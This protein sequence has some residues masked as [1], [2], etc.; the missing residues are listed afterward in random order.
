VITDF[1]SIQP[2]D[3]R[4]AGS[5]KWSLFPDTIG[6]F[7]AEMDFGTAPEVTAALHDI[8]DQGL[9]GYLPPWLAESVSVACAEWQAKQYGWAVPSSRVHPIADVIKGLEI[10][11]EHYSRP[12]SPVIM[13][14]PAYMPFLTV[15][16]GLGRSIIQVPLAEEDGRYAFDLDALGR[17]FDEGGHLMVLCNPYNPV[18]RVF[19]PDELTAVSEVVAAHDGRVFS[20]EIHAPLIYPG[21]RHVPYASL[22]EV[23]AGH[24]V[25]ATSASK[26]WNLP[27][28]K[29]AQ[30]IISNDAD[31]EVWEE[32]G[33]WV[34]HGTSNPGVVANAAAYTSGK[35]WLDKVVGYLDNNRKLLGEL[36]A[37][38]LP[39]IK[40][41][42]PEGTYIGW[43]DC[44]DLDLGMNAADFFREKAG[45]TLTD[46]A[47]CGAPG[48]ARIIFAT[49]A[50]VLTTAIRQMGRAVREHAPN[51]A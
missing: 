24:T 35:P 45:V 2:E 37:A 19:T 31:A 38:E 21:A 4:A 1:D 5:M 3:L 17:A 26:A 41:T 44:R 47:A 36:L 34:G 49:P 43:L 39:M 33:P 32:F 15:P 10:A 20:D 7:V 40:Y 23:A 27:G 12:G 51:A 11:I 18:G 6:A 25:T 48:F 42:P 28:L 50:P 13:P 22:S 16:T 9:F 14:V 29:C 8:V 46:G 30:M